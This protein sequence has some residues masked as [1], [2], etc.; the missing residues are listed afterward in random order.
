MLTPFGRD[1]WTHDGASVVGALGFHYPTRMAVVRLAAGGL[2]IWSPTD[3]TPELRREID[4][5]GTVRC[6]VAPNTMHHTFISGWKQAWPEADL[7]A[8]PQLAAKRADLPVDAMLT[9]SPPDAWR[10]EIDQVILPATG[11]MTEAVFFHR[12]SGTVLFT[13][14]LQNLP[15]SWYSGW[16][17]LIARLDLMLMPEPGVPRKFRLAFTDKAA[18]RAAIRQ[19]L[20]WP[21][22]RVLM[23]HGTPVT[24]DAP[25]YLHRAFGWLFR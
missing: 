5:L 13:D 4:G 11:I 17:A 20:T 15:P 21:V 14:L 2:F 9:E 22:E 3:L 24:A 7:F 6:L 25:A 12:A 16:R 19:V 10:S 1:I 8:L 18:T 23:A